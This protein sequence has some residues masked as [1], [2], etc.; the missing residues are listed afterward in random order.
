M[1]VIYPLSST[2]GSD[3]L[4]SGNLEGQTDMTFIVSS[5]SQA[6]PPAERPNRK[7]SGRPIA[8]LRPED[9]EHTLKRRR[10]NRESAQR[11]RLKKV[12][13]LQDVTAQRDAAC[14]ERNILA[15]RVS[16]LEAQLAARAPRPNYR[17]NYRPA[18]ALPYRSLHSPPPQDMDALREEVTRVAGAVVR[19]RFDEPYSAAFRILEEV[20]KPPPHRFLLSTWE[21]DGLDAP[22]SFG[23]AFP[24]P[25][26]DVGRAGHP[27]FQGAG[28]PVQSVMAPAYA[29]NAALPRPLFAPSEHPL[30]TEP[31]FLPWQPDASTSPVFPWGH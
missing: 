17:P 3:P 29:T 13:E 5:D 30:V 14:A 28:L 1:K 8:P 7:T 23:S 19:H 15:Q 20:N 4:P 21:Q 25:F 27:T 22:A 2:H 10:T 11:A 24:P 6:S 26:G 31:A 16:E 9:S 18:L 12:H